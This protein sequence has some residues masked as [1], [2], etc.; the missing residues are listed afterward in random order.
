LLIV[1]YLNAEEE[2]ER[3]ITNIIGA[4]TAKHKSGA[5]KQTFEG[6]LYSAA[7]EKEFT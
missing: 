1:S 2:L 3:K 7:A 5:I 4:C 6:N